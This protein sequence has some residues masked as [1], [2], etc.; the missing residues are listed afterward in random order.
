[1]SEVPEA[2]QWAAKLTG[3]TLPDAD[4]DLLRRQAAIWGDAARQVEG[5]LGE[6][7]AVNSS[8]RA[9]V[10]GSP[11]DA[12]SDYMRQLSTTLPALAKSA[13]DLREMTDNFLLNLLHTIRLVLVMLVYLLV[14]LAML[15]NTLFGFAAAPA[16]ITGVR[17]VILT[18][19]RQ[20]LISTTVGTASMTA[21]ET[22][23]QAIEILSGERKHLDGDAIKNMA[24]GG[25]IGGA[26]F[27]LISGIG[28]LVPKAD[29]LIGRGV[30]AGLS[31][32]VGT[33]ATDAATGAEGN[34]G[35]GFLGG[36]MF[37][38]TPGVAGGRKGETTSV[39]DAV[40]AVTSLPEKAPSFTEPG[41]VKTVGTVDP[42]TGT[43]TGAT[44]QGAGSAGVGR[45]PSEAL[46]SSPEGVG[47]PEAGGAGG[48]RTAAAVAESG[49]TAGR[50]SAGAA[51]PVPGVPD[52]AGGARGGAASAAGAEGGAT[53]GVSA[54]R[55][56]SGAQGTRA[57]SGLP[58]FEGGP[59]P[60][61][62]SPEGVPG[63]PSG[64]A[65]SVDG[66]GTM[67]MAGPAGV[68]E[69]ARTVRLSADPAGG[70]GTRTGLPDP[71]ATEQV[72]GA[73][74]GGRVPAGAGAADGRVPPVAGPSGTGGTSG[75]GSGLGPVGPTGTE[76]GRT[77]P[78]AA[79]TR[80]AGTT[81]NAAAVRGA[82]TAAPLVRGT[83]PA[84]TATTAPGR[85]PDQ[86]AGAGSGSPTGALPDR[87]VMAGPGDARGSGLGAAPSPASAAGGSVAAGRPGTPGGMMRGAGTDP[88]A[89][90]P[91][92]PPREPG[93]SPTGPSATATGAAH[94][95]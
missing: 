4:P 12:F 65:G 64:A 2:L 7:N 53:A 83:E 15:A 50:G 35:L 26:A 43:G 34:L 32:L 72:R 14:E 47:A 70:T 38:L 82:G 78:A 59:S 55:G 80:D 94:A 69:G 46:S 1:M 56:G 81:P 88:A 17:Q 23:L 75:A 3:T 49:G 73:S 45:V 51:E 95:P 89:F 37:G 61:A 21:L 6:I 25:A 5:L 42:G 76:A 48:G 52:E 74:G 31:G 91:P 54:V 13:D 41:G 9:N 16:L 87:R 90:V 84:G 85:V 40:E 57:P 10:S 66:A 63:R 39:D 33:A 24:I 86:G 77:E 58:G 68:P 28:R 36:F 71:A 20:L 30:V 60:A 27:P 67:P 92:A 44:G 79:G 11:A 62:A 19:L 93:T 8:V 29:S 18:I 22:L